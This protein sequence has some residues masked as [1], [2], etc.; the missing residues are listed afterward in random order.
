VLSGGEARSTYWIYRS[1]IVPRARNAGFEK[2]LIKPAMG[3]ALEEAVETEC[4][5]AKAVGST[6]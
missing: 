2:V 1:D 6:R 3:A 5:A 4:A